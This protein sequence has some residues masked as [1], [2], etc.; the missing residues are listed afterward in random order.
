MPTRL[1][2]KEALER[3]DE[4]PAEPPAVSGSPT[5]LR[6][7]MAG[8]I[9]QPVT[10]IQAIKA[11]GMSLREAHAAIDQIVA[12]H[13]VTLDLTI[14]DGRVPAAEFAALGIQAQLPAADIDV[15]AIREGL[16]LTV[17]EFAIRFALDPA[18]VQNW[19]QGHT[20]PDPAAAVL[21]RVIATNPAAVDAA[22]MS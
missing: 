10:A 17:Q 20:R 18:T 14:P 22:L 12:G 9:L 21:L 16:D 8:P 4:I 1:S 13:T 2:F 15:R 3:Q 7:S 6:L 11:F 5:R 19:E